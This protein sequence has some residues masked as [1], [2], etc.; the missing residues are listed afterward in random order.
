MWTR[1]VVVSVADQ[2]D[3]AEIA[4]LSVAR[5]PVAR[6]RQRPGRA[7]RRRR[8]PV[9]HATQP[10]L[11]RVR[12]VRLDVDREPTDAVDGLLQLVGL[13]R[14]VRRRLRQTLGAKRAQQQ[15]QKQVQHLHTQLIPASK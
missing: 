11:E 8:S 13:G 6:A 9:E 12:H 10:A 14:L 7:G 4:H 1:V 3:A 2:V 15:R 5:V